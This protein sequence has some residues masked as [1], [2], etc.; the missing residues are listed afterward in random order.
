MLMIRLEPFLGT[1][2]FLGP[3]AR[4]RLAGGSLYLGSHDEFVIHHDHGSWTYG[5]V[6]YPS[7][8]ICQ[9]IRLRLGS[10]PHLQLDCGPF[11]GIRLA[12]NE[13][14]IADAKRRLFARL[15]PENGLWALVGGMTAVSNVLI[16]PATGPVPAPGGLDP[17]YAKFD[18]AENPYLQ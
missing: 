9:P 4:A 2:T 17:D 3:V 5:V 8:A 7:V 13:L 12:Q 10:P 6:S 14:Q 16:F 15:N 11:E 1:P 18:T